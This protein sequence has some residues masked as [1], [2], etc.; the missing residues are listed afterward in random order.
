MANTH[1]PHRKTDSHMGTHTDRHMRGHLLL[2]HRSQE[3]QQAGGGKAGR[4]LLGRCLH[5]CQ[6]RGAGGAGDPC[7]PRLQGSG[8]CSGPCGCCPGY[9]GPQRPQDSQGQEPELGHGTVGTPRHGAQVVG[10]GGAVAGAGTSEHPGLPPPIGQSSLQ[11]LTS[12]PTVP[13]SGSRA[14][15]ALETSGRR[16]WPLRTHLL[17]DMPTLLPHPQLLGWDR[18]P[19]CRRGHMSPSP[20]LTSITP[21]AQRSL[22]L[23][24][25][26]LLGIEV[27]CPQGVPTRET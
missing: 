22:V 24:E 14:P 13:A 7:T 18:E 27:S 6:G 19:V 4:G 20:F 17:S 9:E 15:A 1:R 26:G 25:L 11:A 12:G 10:G 3:S 23:A 16:P 8:S 2:V 5:P 21:R